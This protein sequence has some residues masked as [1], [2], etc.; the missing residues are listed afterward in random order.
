MQVLLSLRPVGD[1]LEEW[2]KPQRI[3][4]LQNTNKKS[5]SRYSIL[6]RGGTIAGSVVD[7]HDCQ[8]PKKEKVN[9]EKETH[10]VYLQNLESD[11]D[12][13]IEKAKK[14]GRVRPSSKLS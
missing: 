8:S 7:V 10:T 6:S 3:H 4:E 11:Q 12:Y 1:G 13:S 14:I 5:E 2:R 9:L